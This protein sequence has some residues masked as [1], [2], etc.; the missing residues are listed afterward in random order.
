MLK[1]DF[2]LHFDVLNDDD[3]ILA[4]L[5]ELPE[6][7]RQSYKLARWQGLDPLQIANRLAARNMPTMP[8]DVAAYVS[9]ALKHV[10]RRL[11]EVAQQCA[12]QDTAMIRAR[13]FDTHKS[14]SKGALF[15]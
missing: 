13:C 15:Q 1:D 6:E 2:A 14:G 11:A 12:E 8:N 3:A 9:K 5:K 7:W 10:K 4:A